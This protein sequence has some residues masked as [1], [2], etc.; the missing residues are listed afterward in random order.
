MHEGPANLFDRRGMFKSVGAN[1]ARVNS[2]IIDVNKYFY[3]KG[4]RK[5]GR[6]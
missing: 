5:G 3:K 1:E 4:G 2:S 6:W